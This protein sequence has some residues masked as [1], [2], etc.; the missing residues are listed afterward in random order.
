MDDPFTL[1]SLKNLPKPEQFWN[2]T[3]VFIYGLISNRLTFELVKINSWLP[4]ARQRDP[5]EIDIVLLNFNDEYKRL[6]GEL[7]KYKSNDSHLGNFV[8]HWDLFYKSRNRLMN[9]IGLEGTEYQADLWYDTVEIVEDELLTSEFLQ[10]SISESQPCISLMI[11]DIKKLGNISFCYIFMLGALCDYL[12]YN[13]SKFEGSQVVDHSLKIN[14]S[15]GEKIFEKSKRSPRNSFGVGVLPVFFDEDFLHSDQ[16]NFL[17][18]EI[19]A[20]KLWKIA[21]RFPTPEEYY[22]KLNGIYKKLLALD[23]EEYR[24][25]YGVRVLEN[26]LHVGTNKYKL[27]KPRKVYEMIIE[28]F[29]NNKIFDEEK[30]ITSLDLA[31]YLKNINGCERISADEIFPA[32]RLSKCKKPWAKHFK[33]NSKSGSPKSTDNVG[34]YLEVNPPYFFDASN[35]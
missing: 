19:Q 17:S 3:S 26:E 25:K 32:D 20:I 31:S 16:L 4:S 11:D 23:Y 30:A 12:I 1:Y 29:I 9:L 18:D 33:F 27:G 14:E 8:T 15:S 2:Q 24:K 22:K 35:L 34:S 21:R 5:D 13:Y 7:S 28:Y 10:E 6:A